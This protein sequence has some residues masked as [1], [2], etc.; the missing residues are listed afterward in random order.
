MLRDLHRNFQIDD[1]LSGLNRYH[2]AIDYFGE[3]ISLLCLTAVAAYRQNG[4][5][6]PKINVSLEKL[7]QPSLGDWNNLLNLILKWYRRVRVR[8]SFPLIHAD[9]FKHIQDISLVYQGLQQNVLAIAELNGVTMMLPLGAPKPCAWQA[10][11]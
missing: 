10:G 3:V 11:A 2:R 7:S 6:D 1:S 9:L 5:P 8:S 4:L